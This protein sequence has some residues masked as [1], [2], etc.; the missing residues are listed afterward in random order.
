MSMTWREWMANVRQGD[1]YFLLNRL[2]HPDPTDLF[3]RNDWIDEAIPLYAGTPLSH[4]GTT[5][6]W[7]VRAKWQTLSG[8]AE[9]LDTMPFSDNSWGWAYHSLNNWEE[10]VAHWQKYQLI[11]FEE[12]ERVLRLFDPRV[13]GVLIPACKPAD[14][15]SLLMPLADC[16][17]PSPQGNKV[18][19]RLLSA[20]NSPVPSRF[21]PGVHLKEAWN[22]SAQARKN[23]ADNFQIT[24]W[25]AYPD[26]ALALDEPPG[27]LLSLINRSMDDYENDLVDV[28]W[29][30][31]DMFLRYLKHHNLIE[32]YPG[33]A[34]AL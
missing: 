4:L 33:T 24:F 28:V 5:G 1:V 10:Q 27:R 31:N 22:Q 12:E 32:N 17:I 14:W 34:D 26:L 9:Q 8:M 16:C 20:G 2:A 19:N 30:R 18:I 21:E 15:A 23:V 6:P 11:W 29:L 3:Y 7:L 13:A 25:E